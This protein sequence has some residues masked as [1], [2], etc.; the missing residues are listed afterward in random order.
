[1][2]ATKHLVFFTLSLG[3][4][5]SAQ[6]M[7]ADPHDGHAAHHPQPA[8]PAADTQATD[9]D[10]APMDTMPQAHGHQRG[11]GALH[12]GQH[13]RQHRHRHAEA[14]PDQAQPADTGEHSGHRPHAA[15]H[16]HTHTPVPALTDAD[17]AAAFPLLPAHQH[18]YGPAPALTDADRLA[19][20]PRLPPH[21]MHTGGINTFV[22]ADKLEWQ[23][24]DAGSAL[25]WDITSWIGGDIDRLQIRS[26]GERLNGRTED[27]ELQLYWGHAIG[28]WWETV[29][30]LRQDFKPGAPQTW[31]A[32]GI[33]GTPL[34]GLETEATAFLGEG[35]QTAARLQAEYDLLITNRLI[36]QPRAEA[37]LYGRN[38][39]QRG[40]GAGLAD[41]QFGLRL[42]YE[43]RREFAPYIGVNW[44]H[45]Y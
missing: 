18:G 8:A 13:H 40:I 36:L 28:P 11:H 27:A 3:L 9:A 25:A 23:D 37:N 14:Q 35:G 29:A 7:G 22:L 2:T 21:A 5:A 44:S 30:G 39:P 10:A 19:A 31:A 24:A 41:T 34:Y 20:F 42:R 16:P 1:M 43:I 17:R 45:A 32:F 4:L 12:P 26:E 15:A 33:Q 38:D 6:A